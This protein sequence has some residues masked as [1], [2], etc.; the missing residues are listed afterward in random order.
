MF[1]IACITPKGIRTVDG[2]EREVDVIVCAT[3]FDVSWRPRFKF[4]GR[5]G[6]ELDAAWA[7]EPRSYLSICLENMPNMHIFNG[8]YNCGGNGNAIPPI[9]AEGD[10]IIKCINKIQRQNIRSMTIQTAAVDDL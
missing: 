3:G 1:S 10:Y 7:E 8:P 5:N 2:V 6:F 9:E 4:V